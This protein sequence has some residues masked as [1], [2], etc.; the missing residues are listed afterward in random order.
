MA[1]RLTP[2]EPW[3]DVLHFAECALFVADHDLRLLWCNDAFASVLGWP[4]ER[5]PTLDIENLSHPDDRDDAMRIARVSL[6]SMEPRSFVCRMLDA[7][8]DWRWIRWDGRPLEDRRVVGRA[9]RL[10]HAAP[11]QARSADAAA[12][13]VESAAI[14]VIVHDFNNLLFAL[15]GGIELAHEQ[16]HTP[17]VLADTLAILERAV[18]QARAVNKRLLEL[19]CQR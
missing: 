12:P 4:R 3:E 17:D 16:R 10:D 19:V 9:R 11:A 15:S 14:E 6:A 7:Q 8:G 1:G 2:S 13:E 5:L 18:T